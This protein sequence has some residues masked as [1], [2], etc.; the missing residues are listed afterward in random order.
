MDAVEQV[1]AIE[2]EVI[3]TAAD[4]AGGR[5]WAENFAAVVKAVADFA[6]DERMGQLEEALR[7]VVQEEIAKLLDAEDTA[8]ATVLREMHDG[9]HNRLAEIEKSVGLLV[10]HATFMEKA[11]IRVTEAA[12][13]PQGD[14]AE[15]WRKSLGDGQACDD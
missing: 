12:Q 2:P 15:E 7:K 9:I 14:E 11:L 1:Q 6:I 3:D 4:E 10:D 8:L 13:E 5:A